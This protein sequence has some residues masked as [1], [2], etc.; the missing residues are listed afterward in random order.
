MVHMVAAVAWWSAAALPA[1]W[2]GC[3]GP[4]GRC[5]TCERN[6]GWFGSGRAVILW[7]GPRRPALL[8]AFNPSIVEWM[9]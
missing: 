4:R 1:L 3:A 9:L 5:R 2:R 7:S 8:A 6:R